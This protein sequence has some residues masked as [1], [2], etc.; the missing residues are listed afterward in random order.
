[1]QRP[2]F[3]GSIADRPRSVEA[4][5]ECDGPGAPSRTGDQR[6][7]EKPAQLKNLSRAPGIGSVLLYPQQCFGFLS[8]GVLR[9]LVPFG[10]CREVRDGAIRPGFQILRSAKTIANSFRKLIPGLDADD[11]TSTDERRQ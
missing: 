2:G 5:F 8:Q 6:L 4:A 1:M 7:F 9:A 3:G 11:Q 10:P